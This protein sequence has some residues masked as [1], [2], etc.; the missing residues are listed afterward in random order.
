MNWRLVISIS[1]LGLLLAVATIYFA[2]SE[3]ELI[4]WM[5]LFLVSAFLVARYVD[6]NIFLHGLFTGI[7]IFVWITLADSFLF[8]K[9]YLNHRGEVEAISNLG[10]TS[11]VHSTLVI[12][13]PAAGLVVG[14]IIGVLALALSPFVKPKTV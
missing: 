13:G 9:Y 3:T 6:E 14:S 7:F 5:L 8:G 1:L 2:P 12:L 4:L 10:M 11:S